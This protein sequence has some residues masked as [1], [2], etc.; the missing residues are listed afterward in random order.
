MKKDAQNLVEF[1]FVFPL[2]I[3]LVMAIFE[4][5]MFYRTVHAVQNVALQA[6]ANAATQII[7]DSQTSTSFGNAQF[8]KAADVAAKIVQ[9][10][11]GSLGRVNFNNFDLEVM[12]EYGAPPYSIYK[13]TSDTKIDGSKP[14]V[15]LLVDCTDPYG[16]GVSTQLIYHYVTIIFAAKV[17]LPDGNVITIIPSQVEISSSKIQQYN[18][19]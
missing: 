8:N 2:V 16:K 4:L 11:Q 18:Q 10:K 7:T 9:G 5:S 14:L 13:F 6:A 3:I 19:I 17:P 15:T 1:V 12:E